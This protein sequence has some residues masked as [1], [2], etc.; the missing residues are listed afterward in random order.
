MCG[1]WLWLQDYRAGHPRQSGRPTGNTTAIIL[2]EGHT[3]IV[4]SAKNTK[5]IK[6]TE[7]MTTNLRRQNPPG[8]VTDSV[9]RRRAKV[10][11][12]S[13][14]SIFMKREKRR[15]DWFMGLVG[16]NLKRNEAIWGVSEQMGRTLTRESGF[17]AEQLCDLGRA[18]KSPWALVISCKIS[19][20]R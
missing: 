10:M 5:I 9:Y 7:P 16:N 11:L 1:T 12:G 17:L 6:R 3:D 4:P 8:S 14:P 19:G 13:S 15:V 20:L 18:C 2:G